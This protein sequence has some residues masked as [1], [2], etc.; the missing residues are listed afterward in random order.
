MIQRVREVVTQMNQKIMMY[1]MKLYSL[2]QAQTMKKSV[3][4]MMKVVFLQ[5]MGYLRLY[6]SQEMVL[7]PGIQLL[8]A[9]GNKSDSIKP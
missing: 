3:I 4:K 1:M 2:N 8:S 5:I 7:K 6:M 9:K